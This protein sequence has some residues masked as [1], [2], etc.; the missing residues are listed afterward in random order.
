LINP[1]KPIPFASSQV[2]HL[3]DIDMKNKKNFK[4]QYLEILDLINKPDIIV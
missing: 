3:Y 2:H 1:E 4:E